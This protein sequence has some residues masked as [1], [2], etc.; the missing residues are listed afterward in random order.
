M[1]PTDGGDSTCRAGEAATLGGALGFAR[2]GVDETPRTGTITGVTADGVDVEV[3]GSTLHFTWRGPSIADDFTVGAE[4]TVYR[5]D[6]FDA[7]DSP[8][9]PG[10]GVGLRA[11][12]AFG[13]TGS[14]VV[15]VALPIPD[16]PTVSLVEGCTFREASGGCGQPAGTVTVYDLDVDGTPIAAGEQV[17]TDDALVL[18]H[19]AAQFPGYGS[20]MCVVEAGFGAKVAAR[21]TLDPAATCDAIEDEYRDLLADHISC[22]DDTDCVVLDGQCSVGLGGCYEVANVDLSAQ[23]AEL[24]RRYQESG[25]T[26]GVCDCAGPPR[27]FCNM[28][29][30]GLMP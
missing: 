3:G 6:G 17:E 18:H 8:S 29:G 20:D 19:G 7:L 22:S 15:G 1:D 2:G 9:G 23:L 21:V 4:A 5:V 26:M 14:G 27:A 25:C 24:G 10:G 13:F 12:N 16:G 11:M 30:C 28:G